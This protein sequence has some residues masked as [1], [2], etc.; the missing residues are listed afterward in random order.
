MSVNVHAV[1]V[2]GNS[3]IEGTEECDDGH[4][5]GVCQN[6]CSSTCTL[7]NCPSYEA[8]SSGCGWDNLLN[9]SIVKAAY[10][11]YDEAW[12]GWFIFMLLMLFQFMIMMKT[13]SALPGLTIMFLF[14]G[15]YQAGLS[16]DFYQPMPVL[17]IGI[18]Y[19]ITTLLIG[20]VIYTLFAKRN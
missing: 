4:H 13:R 2:C 7:N 20:A 11:T 17:A 3:I 16:A 15:L 1:Q 8:P 18:I 19:L 5:N 6:S 9:G 14:L 10:C 12:G